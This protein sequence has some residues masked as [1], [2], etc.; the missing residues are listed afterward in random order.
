MNVLVIGQGG[1]EH[2]LVDKVSQSKIVNKIYA[3]PGN[4]GMKDIATLVDINSEDNDK[5]VKFSQD[6]QIDL[7]IVGPEKELNNGLAD[8][9]NKANIKVFGPTKQAATIEASK[10]YA[11]E[12][13]KKY[14]IPTAKYEYF[15]DVDKAKD[16]LSKQDL[17]IVIKYDGLMAGKGVYIVDNLNEGLSILEDLLKSDSDSVVIEEFITGDEF[18]LLC[19]VKGDKVYPLPTARDFKRIN[20]NDQG[21]NTGGMGAISPYHNVTQDKLDLAIKVMNDTAQALV[22]E[23]NPFSGLLYGGFMMN[24]KGVYV[25][26]F[27][28]RFG[29]PETEAI[30][31][32]IDNDLVE[33][34][35][36]LFEDKPVTFNIKDKTGVG[37]VLSAPGYPLDYEKGIDLTDYLNL[38]F[39]IYHMGTKEQDG[40]IVSNGGRVLFIYNEGNTAKDAF[41]DIYKELDKINGPLH[42]R[43]D[44]IN[45]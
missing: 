40:K 45:Y 39:K 37:L 11:K 43:R 32:L 41:N 27:N 6:N 14:N 13:M 19:F 22:K 33:Q 3:L 8:A 5:I 26:E 7:V 4:V 34:M 10:N 12:L 18:T 23:N 21:L 16:Y 20:D 36:N 44:L 29:D 31:N 2:A 1:R 35:I 42:Y 38:P 15:T 25:I 30:L 28:A 24:D 9:L 17:P